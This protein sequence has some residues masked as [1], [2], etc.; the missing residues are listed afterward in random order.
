V[1]G[2]CCFAIFARQAQALGE[3]LEVGGVPVAAV[4]T[5][6]T[7]HHRHLQRMCELPRTHGQPRAPTEEFHVHAAV[8]GEC[9]VGHDAHHASGFQRFLEI[10]HQLRPAIGGIDDVAGQLRIQLLE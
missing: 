3:Q 2:N 1:T 8:G 7:Q 5:A 4:I 6:E 9:A 10:E